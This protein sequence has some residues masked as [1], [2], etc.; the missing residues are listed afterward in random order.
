ME[1]RK[2]EIP[3]RVGYL[4][5]INE[6]TEM[7]SVVLAL[8]GLSHFDEADQTSLLDVIEDYFT[9]PSCHSQLDS[10]SDSDNDPVEGNYYGYQ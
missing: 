8:N 2:R 7:A 5:T 3:Y 1:S 9:S 6:C 4:A 10:E